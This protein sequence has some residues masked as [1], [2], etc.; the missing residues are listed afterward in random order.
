VTYRL[1]FI[2]ENA[3][4]PSC[5]ERVRVALEPVAVVHEIAVDEA[6]DVAMVRAGT[7]TDVSQDAVDRV[8]REASEGAGHAYRVRPGSWRAVS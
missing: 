8:L 5:A 3:G 1:E 7:A 6:A 4:C 2:V